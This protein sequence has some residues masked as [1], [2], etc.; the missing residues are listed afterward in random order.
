[1]VDSLAALFAGVSLRTPPRDFFFPRLQDASLLL[2]FLLAGAVVVYTAT[3]YRL[4]SLT[5]TIFPLDRRRSPP[6]GGQGEQAGPGATAEARR[7]PGCRGGGGTAA[8]RG[9]AVC[10]LRA[11]SVAV[12]GRALCGWRP[13]R[14]RPGAGRPQ[15]PGGAWRLFVLVWV[16]SL[17]LLP[18]TGVLAYLGSGPGRKRL[19]CTCRISY[20]GKRG[21]SRAA[22]GRWLAWAVQRQRAAAGPQGAIM[23]FLVREVVG[24][25]LVVAGLLACTSVTG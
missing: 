11:I 7:P 10:L 13:L 23:R 17:V 9:G 14:V 6:P 20:G 22:F 18:L 5:G 8:L 3:H 19:P 16:A 25:L 1:M 2:D 24:W 21:E 4:V 15:H 12:A